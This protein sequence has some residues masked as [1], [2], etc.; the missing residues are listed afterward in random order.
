MR[1]KT[2]DRLNVARISFLASIVLGV[3]GMANLFGQTRVGCGPTPA[4]QDPAQP[5]PPSYVTLTPDNLDFGDQV[6]RRTSAAKRIMVRNMGASSLY[7]DSVDLGGDNPNSF[8]IS[9]DT[10]TGAKVEPDRTCMVEVTF[11]P[12]RTGGRNARI[13]ITDN[14]LDS[15]QRL[16]LK[17]NG[18]NSSAVAPF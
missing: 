11:T 5:A 10:C 18:I 17:G 9:K 6:V 7:V 2:R 4:A 8:A 13:K 12:S 1:Y 3:F 15:P 16:K 14:A